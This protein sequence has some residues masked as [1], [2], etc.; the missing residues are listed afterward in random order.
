MKLTTIKTLFIILFTAMML[1]LASTV[2]YGS[3]FKFS[4]DTSFR[5][6]LENKQRTWRLGNNN[7]LGSI[8]FKDLTAL[9][10]FTLAEVITH[11]DHG[12]P[13]KFYAGS[14]L[15]SLVEYT[16]LT[17]D[18]VFD[19]TAISGQQ[20]IEDAFYV[21]FEPKKIRFEHFGFKG[22]KNLHANG[23][24]GFLESVP[25]PIPVPATWMLAGIGL[26]AITWIKNRFIS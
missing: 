2:S 17:P 13:V 18:T 4:Q 14:G 10:T 9:S 15:T 11:I 16:E 12:T 1:I 20:R 3:S 8:G 5:F 7:H 21:E 24:L 23:K 19:Y 6:V 22:H 25:A 26:V